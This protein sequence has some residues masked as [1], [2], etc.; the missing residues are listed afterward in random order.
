[1]VGHPDGDNEQYMI[2]NIMIKMINES[3]IKWH[4]LTVLFYYIFYL[5][6]MKKTLSHI[7]KQIFSG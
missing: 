2:I 4:A 1:M 7:Q 5:Q 6:W 3:Y